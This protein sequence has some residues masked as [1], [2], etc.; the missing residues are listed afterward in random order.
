MRRRSN[1]RA[2]P[3]FLYPR[4][5]P[6]RDQGDDHGSGHALITSSTTLR[7]DRR[8]FTTAATGLGVRARRRLAPRLRRSVSFLSPERRPLFSGL[9]TC[10]SWRVARL[11][12]AEHGFGAEARARRGLLFE[13]PRPSGTRDLPPPKLAVE[14]RGRG[15]DTW[16]WRCRAPGTPATSAPRRPH[17]S[18]L[19]LQ[20]GD[21]LLPEPFDGSRV[22]SSRRASV[23]AT[24]LDHCKSHAPA[25]CKPAAVSSSPPDTP[26]N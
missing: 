14:I 11:G 16:R 21:D 25:F 10:A 8:A 6:C 3:R 17:G 13:R 22:R 23:G 9:T 15:S 19:F 24:T 20:T 26:L 1:A 18:P 4:H 5:S 7:T 12:P 2:A